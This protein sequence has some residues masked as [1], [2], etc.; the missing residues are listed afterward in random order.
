MIY[1]PLLRS[2]EKRHAHEWASD[3][4]HRFLNATQRSASMLLLQGVSK[5]CREIP[6]IFAVYVIYLDRSSRVLE[7]SWV[8]FE[9][10]LRVR[11]CLFSRCSW[12]TCLKRRSSQPPL[13]S[14]HFASLS[15]SICQTFVPGPHAAGCSVSSGHHKT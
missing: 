15:P 10:F 14:F 2:R 13:V 6:F 1:R 3:C 8:A 12:K 9:M 7:L 11:Y 5:D 4:L